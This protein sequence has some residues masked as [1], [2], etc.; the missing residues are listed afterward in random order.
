MS[1][2]KLV[3]ERETKNK[4]RFKEESDD[5]TIGALYIAKS[6]LADLGITGKDPITIEIKEEK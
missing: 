3:H 4:V 2:V 1:K 6:K 5:P